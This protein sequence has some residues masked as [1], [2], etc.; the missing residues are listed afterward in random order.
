M[1]ELILSIP[2]GESSGNVA[3]D[4]SPSAANATLVGGQFVPGRLGH[5]ARFA[6]EGYAE[7][8]PQLLPLDGQFTFSC[9]I[10]AEQTGAAPTQ[11]WALFKFAGPDQFIYLDLGTSATSW[12]YLVLMQDDDG[13]SAYINSR[14]VDYQAFPDGW[15]KPVGFCVLNDNPSDSAGF[16]TIEDLVVYEG[17]APDQITF[18]PVAQMELNYFINGVNFKN[19]GVHVS[20][21]DGIIDNLPMKEPFRVQWDDYHGEVI[22]LT[23]PRYDV[24]TIKL[25]CF[26]EGVGKDEFLDRVKAFLSQFEKPGTQRLMLQ[27]HTTKPLVYEVYL[28]ESINLRKKWSDSLMVGT[29]ELVLREP[30]PL[31]RV[32]KFSGAGL[33]FLTMST[34]KLVNIYWGDGQADKDISGS[35]FTFYHTYAEGGDHYAIITGVIEE[36]IGFS[37]T[38]TVVWNRL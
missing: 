12:T 17:L 2:F 36:I 26:I 19:Y 20:D 30:E 34:Q 31:K 4:E 18:I 1:A 38:G 29:F 25:S 8:D 11:T 24:R 13:V 3:H 37:T 23:R 21:S 10:K 7:V 6:G 9:W 35:A 22:D 5:A 28:R 16:A 33:V 32:V 15:G 27:V 14:P